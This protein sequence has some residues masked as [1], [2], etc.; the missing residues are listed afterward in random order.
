M[1]Q[2]GDYVLYGSDGVCAVTDLCPSPLGGEDIY[3]LLE[4]VEG[5]AGS[6][7]YAPVQNGK[8]K[9]RR[10]MTRTEA[11]EL[12][13]RIPFITTLPIPSEKQRKETYRNA[14]LSGDPVEYVRIIKT[15]YRRRADLSQAK[16]RLP[17]SD[18][19]YD[20]SARQCLYRELSLSLG[21]AYEIMEEY[22]ETE[23]RRRL[24]A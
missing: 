9:M 13:D 22:L 21:V 10:I 18:T 15:V 4:P 12:I 14:M 7:I 6:K 2:K 5:S 20:R 17:D 8:V 11:D 19:D 24:D 3:Y 23:I 1:F 16:K